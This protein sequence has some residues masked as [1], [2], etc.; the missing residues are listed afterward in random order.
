MSA[1]EGGGG[2]SN[3]L[4]SS[5]KGGGGGVQPISDFFLTMGGGA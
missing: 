5:D 4:T 1:N 2:V 3:F